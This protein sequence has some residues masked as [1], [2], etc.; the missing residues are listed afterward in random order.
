MSDDHSTG[1]AVAVGGATVMG[2]ATGMAGWGPFGGFVGACLGAFVGVLV[3]VA[4]R[5]QGTRKVLAEPEMPS[6]TG[7]S[8]EQ[9]MAVVSATVGSGNLASPMLKSLAEIRGLLEKEPQ[10]ALAQV[11]ALAAE[12]PGSPA[13]LAE[14]AVVFDAIGRTEEAAQHATAAIEGSLNQGANPVAARVFLS[15]AEARDRLSLQ[16]STLERLALVLE[17]RGEDE[18]AAWCKSRLAAS[19]VADAPVVSAA[20]PE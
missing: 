1:V 18:Q 17:A 3:G 5:Y 9:V 8:V 11:E 13:V 10:R 19:M 15:F 20:E 2:A 12:Y 14:Q 16:P 6:M 4:V 7:L